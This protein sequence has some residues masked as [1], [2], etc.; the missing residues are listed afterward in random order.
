[1][2]ASSAWSSTAPP[3][4]VPRR[5]RGRGSRGPRVYA[6]WELASAQ[7]IVWAWLFYS[8]PALILRWETDFG[9]AK[10]ELTGA[11]TLSIALSAVFSPLAGRLI[12][13]GLGRQVLAG[14][15]LAGGL[16]IGLV[17]L[18]QSLWQ[19]YALWCLIGVATAF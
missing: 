8:F 18:V 3:R 10:A 15:A 9:W 16:C 4:S 1:M 17:G 6:I 11:V 5:R 13:R 7:T 12:D 19:F 14:G 2:S